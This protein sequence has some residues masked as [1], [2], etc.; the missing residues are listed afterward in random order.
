MSDICWHFNCLYFDHVTFLFAITQVSPQI[1]SCCFAEL[2]I[3]GRVL[4][5]G[6]HP[7]V[8]CAAA[9]VVLLREGTATKVHL[10]F[11]QFVGELA[12]YGRYKSILLIP[13]LYVE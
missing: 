2:L 1:I 12:R 8:H 9:V 4:Q 7:N 3:E 11:G 6:F 13:L 10:L 5:V